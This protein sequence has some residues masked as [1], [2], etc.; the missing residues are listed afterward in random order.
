MQM[1]RVVIAGYVSKTPDLR[2]LP[3]GTPVANV[4]VGESV[5]Y[6]DGGE[7]RELTNWHSLSFYGKLA[8]V[9]Q[10]L[11]KGDSIYVDGRIEQR[12]FVARDGGKPRT[13]Y[14][15]VVSQC[16]VIAPLRRGSKAAESAVEKNAANGSVSAG[17]GVE[18]DWPIAG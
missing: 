11:K 7:T 15:I 4:R 18:N 3:S 13:V 6:A 12:Q 10:A 17:A 2:R 16:H 5:R 1:N 8:S 9:A 14:E